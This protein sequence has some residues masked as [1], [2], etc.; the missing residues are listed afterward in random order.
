MGQGGLWEGYMLTA[1]MLHCAGL[2]SREE[3]EEEDL[4]VG[5]TY[6]VPSS[7]FVT[8]CPA[9][10]LVPCHCLQFCLAALPAWCV[11]ERGREETV[12][13]LPCLPFGG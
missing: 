2:Y 6:L 1:H 8:A 10:C 3:E 11:C 9:A 12:A 13:C 4:V 5:L 7:P